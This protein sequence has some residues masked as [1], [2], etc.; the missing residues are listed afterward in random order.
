MIAKKCLLAIGLLALC[1]ATPASAAPPRHAF[2]LVHGAWMG[3]SAWDPVAARLRKDG[4]EVI[5]VELPA[6]GDD[7]TP[8]DKATL[9]GYVEAVVAAIG[10]RKDVV[11]VGHSFGG[12][13]ISGVAEEIPE[14]IG[15]LMYVAAYLPRDGESAYSLS[16]Q[17]K[18][19]HVPKFWSQADP[20]KYTPV[21]IRKEGL[22]DV[23]CNDCSPEVQAYVL[24][25]HREEPVPPMGTPVKLTPGKFGAIPR[26]YIATSADHAVGYGLQRQM[27]QA[28]PV[29]RVVTLKSGHVPM[30]THP[31]KVAAALR[32][33]ASE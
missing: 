3:K 32:Q 11:L 22:I 4:E 1:A 7:P 27:L 13:V 28:T 23:F 21:T 18:D 24:A 2:V 12:V 33:F 8:A 9:H 15:R 14:R 10:E 26:Y 31:K 25:H 19:S 6:H 16:Q 30:L 20:A 5:Q 29:K 17:D